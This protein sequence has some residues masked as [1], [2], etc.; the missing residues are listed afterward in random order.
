MKM[1]DFK[2]LSPIDYG[3][4]VVFVLYIVF[5]VP[6]PSWF[7]PYVDSPLGLVFMFIVTI[8]LFVYTNPL[9]G[10]LYIFVV[11][12]V[13]RRNHYNAPASQIPIGTMQM[14]S[15]VPKPLP[16][17]AEKDADLRAM[18]PPTGPT[19]EEEVIS[20]RAPVGKGDL[21]GAIVQTTFHPVAD[22]S[23]V[24]ASMY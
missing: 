20:V 3:L 4:L 12:E 24:G 16:S 15:R 23:S 5:P 22:K 2:T 6:T 7:V 8:S 11:Y 21:P 1:I 9:L 10:I 18:N 14:A 17:Q 13:L 19:L